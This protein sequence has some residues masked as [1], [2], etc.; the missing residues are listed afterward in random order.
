MELTTTIG[1]DLPVVVEYEID[2]AFYPQT[3]TDSAEYAELLINAV[4]VGGYDIA[5]A[6][7]DKTISDLRVEIEENLNSE[8]N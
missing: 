3:R 5:D 2:G 1:E 8:G 4:L 6:L 7:S